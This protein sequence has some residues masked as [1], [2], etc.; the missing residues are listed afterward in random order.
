M[1]ISGLLFFYR[2]RLREQAVEEVL[3]GFGIAVAVALLFAV[4]VASQSIASSAEEVNRA[5]IGSATLQLRSRGPEGLPE[6]MLG[7]VEALK[8]VKHAAPLLEES[9][10]ILARSGASVP[11]NVA[12][13]VI[14]VASLDGLIHSQPIATLEIGGMGLS[15]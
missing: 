14:S 7:R 5:L 11:V 8:R 12:G 3:A 6:S 2:E 15:R 9:A 13:A 4:T 10:T 1:G